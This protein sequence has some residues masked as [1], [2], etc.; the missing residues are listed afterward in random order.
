MK[1]LTQIHASVPISAVN[2]VTLGRGWLY[3]SCADVKDQKI[4]EELSIAN[5]INFSFG[6]LLLSI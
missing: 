1:F 5:I 3:L 6:K 4:L 2:C